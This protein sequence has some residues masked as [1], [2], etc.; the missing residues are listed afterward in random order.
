MH[1]NKA[2]EN[3]IKASIRHSKLPYEQSAGH[4]ELWGSQEQVLHA[5]QQDAMLYYFPP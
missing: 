4:R 5:F 1:P 3:N 2:R